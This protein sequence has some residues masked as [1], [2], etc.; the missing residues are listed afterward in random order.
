MLKA[1]WGHHLVQ[2]IWNWNCSQ[3]ICRPC[4][5]NIS[6]N[7]L[8]IIFIFV[9]ITKT[10]HCFTDKLQFLI[11][12]KAFFVLATVSQVDWLVLWRAVYLGQQ[13]WRQGGGGHWGQYRHWEGNQH[14]LSLLQPS[15][16]GECIVPY[17]YK[18]QLH[19]LTYNSDIKSS[20][21][22]NFNKPS[23]KLH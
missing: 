20:S 9:K 10:S 22:T 13:T 7:M 3:C 6:K 15:C 11:P 21:S 5:R 12:H 19:D 14:I 17:W 18:T 16:V 8:N 2:S 4:Y 1:Y 23:C